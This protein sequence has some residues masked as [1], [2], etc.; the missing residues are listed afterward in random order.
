MIVLSNTPEQTIELG[1]GIG[2]VLKSGDVVGLVG[3]LGTGKTVMTKGIAKGLGVKVPKYVN[4]PSFVLIKEY[5]G[6]IPL[7]HLDLYRLDTL[8]MLRQIGPEEY[9]YGDGVTVIE[10]AQK[11]EPLLPEE[12]LRVE[13]EVKGT[14]KRK[15]RLIPFGSRYKRLAEKIQRTGDR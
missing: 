2:R 15:I 11:V 5:K 3:E 7:Y 4:S 1:K 9:L 8:K 6:R 13:L 12:Y 14:D 10:W